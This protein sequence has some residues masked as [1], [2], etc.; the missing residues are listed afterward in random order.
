MVISRNKN[1]Q[2]TSGYTVVET[3][4][5]AIALGSNILVSTG[6]TLNNYLFDKKL[7]DKVISHQIP[8]A[9]HEGLSAFDS[10]HRASLSLESESDAGLAKEL[11]YRCAQMDSNHR[12][13]A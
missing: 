10:S 1:L 2:V 9:I 3:P 6:P 7:V 12:P 11:K 8:I 13:T 4:E 5:D